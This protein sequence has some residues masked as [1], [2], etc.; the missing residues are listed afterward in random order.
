MQEKIELL[1]IGLLG[2]KEKL[3]VIDRWLRVMN[4]PN[5][6]HYD[7]DIIWVLRHID[8]LG[9][10]KGSTIIDA[11]AGL[12]MTQFILAA[13]GYNVLSLDFTSREIPRFSRKIFAIEKIDRGL[14]G[15]AH[16]Y[17]EFMNYGQKRSRPPIS[18]QRAM[19]LLKKA[20]DPKRAGLNFYLARHYLKQAVNLYYCLELM[21]DHSDFGK[22]TFLR[23][24]FNNIPLPDSTADALVS[25]SAFEHNTYQDML[26]SI[27]EFMRVV[28]KGSPLIITT[29]AAD[30]QDWYFQAPKAW[31][32]SKETLSSWFDIPQERVS[33]NYRDTSRDIMNS[34]S[35]KGRISGFYKFR[36]ENAL[37]Y[38]DLR[39]IRYIPVGIVKIKA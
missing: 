13:C 8:Q 27:S 1:D 18:L 23:G 37:P 26:A 10:R 31:N 36:G 17:M 7:L 19:L 28:K 39:Q 20:L 35:L 22:I 38:G 25:V 11:G 2:D 3:K 34:P 21:K 29:S 4:W 5:G 9:L 15:Y 16:E 32:F 6:W 12:G 33:F 30:G 14:G 24:T